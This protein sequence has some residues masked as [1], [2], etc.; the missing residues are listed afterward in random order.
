MTSSNLE[1]IF[2]AAASAPTEEV[3]K[4]EVIVVK[5]AN[6]DNL[7]YK[8]VELASYLYHLN[9]QAHLLHLNVESPSFLAL[10]KFLK[11]QYLQHVEDFDN[12]AELV[13]SMDY[14]LPMCQKGLLGAC[15]G[16]KTTTTYEAVPSLT[17]YTKNLE[18][19]GFM[20]KDVFEIAKEV[21]AP[22][23]ENALADIT[24][25]LFKGAW[26]MKSTL[27]SDPSSVG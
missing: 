23:I 26:M 16:F 2:Q 9:I 12:L 24:G 22:D 21:G 4:E 17:L 6:V 13:R 15:K 18:A 20:A 1:Q 27:R 5:E 10:H 3:I 25:H 19:G 8:L 7:I 14:L 11:K